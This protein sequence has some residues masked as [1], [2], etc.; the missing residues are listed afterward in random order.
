MLFFQPKNAGLKVHGWEPCRVPCRPGRDHQQHELHGRARTLQCP[1]QRD[2]CRV[3]QCISKAYVKHKSSHPGSSKQQGVVQVLR[4]QFLHLLSVCRHSMRAEFERLKKSHQST[5]QPYRACIYSSN[6][7]VSCIQPD[8][9]WGG[10][11]VCWS[12]WPSISSI[13]CG[14]LCPLWLA[15]SSRACCGGSD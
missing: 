12:K 7:A 4:Q 10:R 1:E 6:F 13:S 3:S 14:N 8:A 5:L 15:A 9:S 11:T 2:K